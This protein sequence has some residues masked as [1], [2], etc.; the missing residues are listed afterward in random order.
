MTERTL[1]ESFK[2]DP[3]LPVHPRPPQLILEENLGEAM[4]QDPELRKAVESHNKQV[5]M[6]RTLER[7]FQKV[8]RNDPCL[9]GSGKKFKKCCVDKVAC[10]YQLMSR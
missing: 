8:G 9:C 7:S 10:E 1:E 5:H 2:D 4:K 3:M 6:S